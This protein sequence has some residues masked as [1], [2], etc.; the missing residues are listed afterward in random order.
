MLLVESQTEAVQRE[1]D[2]I[3]ASS[4]FA[5][6]ERLCRFLR[7]IVERHL[8]G[9]DQELKE[10]V[11]AVEVFG[12][13][14]DYNPKLDPIVRTEAGRLR[15]RL[16]EYYVGEGRGD[17]L[18][19]EVP[20]GGYIPAFRQPA[21][22]AATGDELS[23]GRSSRFW[24]T[25]A[26]AGL[27]VAMVGVSWWR[28]TRESPPVVIAVLPLE[29]LSH[30]PAEDYFA[31]GLTDEIINNLSAIE[32]LAV[33]SRTSSFALKGTSLNVREVAKQLEAEFILEGSVLRAGEQLRINAQLIRVRDDFALW[34]GKFDRQLTDIFAIQEEISRG[35]TNGLRL[36]L[37]GGRR[38]YETSIE[39]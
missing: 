29:N 12:R 2:R 23:K 22:V 34:S 19:I 7:F 10:P 31:D 1:L 36:K 18:V 24:I 33:R 39:A 28:L 21:T 8:E 25:L 14:P 3:L 37:G 38:R 4:G 20:K 5:R 17:A 15:G 27:A 26:V 30:D 9:R 13:R 32:G 6:N 11:I 16:S 35:I